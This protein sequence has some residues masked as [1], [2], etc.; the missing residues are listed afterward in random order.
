MADFSTAASLDVFVSKNSLRSARSDIEDELG[1]I[2]ADVSVDMPDP[3]RGAPTPGGRS[4][5]VGLSRDTQRTLGRQ[6]S[7]LDTL[8]QH[9]GVSQD[10]DIYWNELL[11]DMGTKLD[12]L[13]QQD[14]DGMGLLP[15][16]LLMRGRKRGTRPN[17]GC[18]S[19]MFECRSPIF[20]FRRP[21]T[22][23]F[24]CRK[25]SRAGFGCGIRPTSPL[26]CG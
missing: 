8:A 14:D 9:A 2:T 10:L 21:T 5:G 1:D 4:G 25:T 26:G 7:Q 12:K 16:S 23:A 15:L 13:G 18:Q 22:S 3:G 17:P 20:A 19:P 11:E 6:T 24:G